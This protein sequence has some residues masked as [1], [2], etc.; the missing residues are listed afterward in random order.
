MRHHLKQREP[1]LEAPHRHQRPSA[2]SAT[3]IVLLIVG[4]T[5]F[6]SGAWVPLV[7]IPLIIVLLFKRV[8]RH[9]TR[10][11]TQLAGAAG[12]QARGG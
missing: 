8:Q 5:K 6:T 10:W 12:L 4:V 11:P 7:V 9:Y 2:R 3:F 1:G